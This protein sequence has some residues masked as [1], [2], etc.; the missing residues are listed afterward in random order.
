MPA[1]WARLA[2]PSIKLSCY[3][4][5]RK[6]YD[7]G[8]ACAQNASRKKHVSRIPKRWKAL[9]P[10][11]RSGSSLYSPLSSNKTPLSMKQTLEHKLGNQGPPSLKSEG[12]RRIANF[13]ESNSIKYHYEPALLIN[14][15]NQKPRIWYPDFYL[16]EISAYIEYFGLV[17][18]QNYD[19]GIKTKE[20]VYSKTGLAVI[21]VY[22][23]TFAGDWQEY[24]M[25]ELE[26]ITVRRYENLMAKPYWSQHKS[27][28]HH[29]DTSKQPR[30]YQ[31]FSNRY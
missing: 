8:S 14:P 2:D 13:L 9:S 17:G 22:P 29:N 7:K 3:I 18:R 25:K 6:I 26:R 19:K 16:P 5:D 27:A 24:I 1:F 30:Y 31:D 15:A 28:T 10:F 4:S 21:P 12:E 20:T 11:D 23:W